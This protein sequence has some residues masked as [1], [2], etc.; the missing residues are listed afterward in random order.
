MMEHIEVPIAWAPGSAEAPWD[1]GHAYLNLQDGQWQ[2]SWW[3][4]APPLSGCLPRIAAKPNVWIE[5]RPG[6]YAP[7][8][9]GTVM[10]TLGESRG[11]MT[12]AT[13]LCV[14]PEKEAEMRA[15]M[16]F[17]PLPLAGPEYGG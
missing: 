12:V 4:D 8:P 10:V 11:G 13:V 16:V 5:N 2:L 7:P 6:L 17:P 1:R 14:T 9:E 15:K 3:E